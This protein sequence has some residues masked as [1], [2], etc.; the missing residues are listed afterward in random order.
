MACNTS[1]A[2]IVAVPGTHD[3]VG[4]TCK[5]LCARPCAAPAVAVGVPLLHDERHVT[6]EAEVGRQHQSGCCLRATTVLTGL[7]H[8]V[9]EALVVE[10]EVDGIGRVTAVTGAVADESVRC[11]MAAGGKVGMPHGLSVGKRRLPLSGSCPNGGGR[12]VVGDEGIRPNGNPVSP[13]TSNTTC[14][15]S[16]IH[17]RLEI[18]IIVQ[19]GVPIRQEVHRF[20]EFDAGNSL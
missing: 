7:R 1:K 17:L 13:K 2:E 15:L 6:V 19:T 5:P 8:T 9:S 20:L 11:C 12:W 16:K 14:V 18:D 4:M 3:T 10:E